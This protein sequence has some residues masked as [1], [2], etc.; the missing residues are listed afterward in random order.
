MKTNINFIIWPMIQLFL[1]VSGPTPLE[2][3]SDFARRPKCA[4][5][6]NVTY[7][8]HIDTYEKNLNA[9]PDRER[10]AFWGGQT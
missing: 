6:K 9:W 5:G 1:H 7:A 8:T 3:L 10:R 2:T 4:M